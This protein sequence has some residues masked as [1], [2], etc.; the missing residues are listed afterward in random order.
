MIYKV[1][2]KFKKGEEKEFLEKLR[3]GRI[4]NLEPDGPSIMKGMKSASV[5]DE[6]FVNWTELCYCPT[7]LAHERETVYDNFFEEFQT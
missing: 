4:E 6:G 2:A 1:K 5:D 3:D 7:P